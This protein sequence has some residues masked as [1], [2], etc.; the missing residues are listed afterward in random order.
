MS[1]CLV[2]SAGPLY[3]RIGGRL[4]DLPAT[5]QD[6]PLR[7]L[8]SCL[9]FTLDRFQCHQA[10][11]DQLLALQASSGGGSDAGNGGFVL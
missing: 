9:K 3:L 10:M 8:P 6:A 5:E 7:Q 4:A 11:L 2:C 1:C